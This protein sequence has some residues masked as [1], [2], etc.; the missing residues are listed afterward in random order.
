VSSL[1]A[2][3]AG[4]VRSLE[5]LFAMAHAIECDAVARYT[6]TAAQL[7]QQGGEQ[8]AGIFEHLADVERGHVHQVTVWAEHSEHAEPSKTPLPWTI[9]DTFDAP[10]GEMAKSK[11]LTPYRALASAVRHEERSFAFWTYVA[12]HADRTDVKEAAEQMAL[13]E[14]EHVSLLRRERRKA[15]HVEGEAAKPASVPIALNALAAF[16]RHLAE[17]IQQ[18]PETA[19]GVQFAASIVTDA[20]RAAAMLEGMEAARG[21]APAMPPLPLGAEADLV[22]VSEYLVD[23]YLRLA[24]ISTEAE[25]LSAAQKLAAVAIYRLATLRAAASG[26]DGH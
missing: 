12:A 14:L 21:P 11:L 8:L 26:I 4:P 2:E 16:E 15:F 20:K 7:R 22:A 10:P 19:A 9:P 24:E 18:R 5:E 25:I 23:A 6:E 13:E 17:A 3:P 1:K